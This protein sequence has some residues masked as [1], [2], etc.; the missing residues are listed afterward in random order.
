MRSALTLPY[1][2]TMRVVPSSPCT[3]T[4]PKAVSISAR[5]PVGSS[6]RTST[7]SRPGPSTLS[8][9]GTCTRRRLFSNATVAWRASETSPERPGLVGVTSTVVSVR[10]DATTST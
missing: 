8:R 7:E 5:D 6:T 2:A 4:D 1:L 3:R 9:P 10:S